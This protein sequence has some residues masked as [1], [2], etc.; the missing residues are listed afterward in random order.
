M[1]LVP[2]WPGTKPWNVLPGKGS[3]STHGAVGGFPALP[4]RPRDRLAS[5]TRAAGSE[6]HTTQP[7][8][9]GEV[10]LSCE[11][12][13]L[14]SAGTPSL[15]GV[16]L[17][18]SSGVGFGASAAFL[19]NQEQEQTQALKSPGARGGAVWARLLWLDVPR[20]WP[21]GF[22]VLLTALR[23]PGWEASV[24]RPAAPRTQK[25]K[26]GG[27]AKNQFHEQENI[28]LPVTMWEKML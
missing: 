15:E 11:R 10:C 17:P 12:D 5:A 16:P 27:P 18:G 24:Q 8:I 19:Q 20:G 22:S 1:K 2:R 9:V 6:R 4:P 3:C 21:S 26:A 7:D 25:T 23:S 13:S 14:N 28:F